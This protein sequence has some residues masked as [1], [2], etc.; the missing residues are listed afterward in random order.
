MIRLY[1]RLLFDL[2]AISLGKHVETSSLIEDVSKQLALWQK[3]S[4]KKNNLPPESSVNQGAG[5]CA[6]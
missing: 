4:R 2:K 6:E 5:E 3:Y 1:W